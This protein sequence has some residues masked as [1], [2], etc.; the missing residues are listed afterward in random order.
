MSHCNPLIHR[1]S[2]KKHLLLFICFIAVTGL[3]AQDK[4]FSL[5]FA[6]NPN[7]GWISAEDTEIEDNID[8]SSSGA[9]LGFS[10]GVMGEIHFTPNYNLALGIN[11]VFTGGKFSGT[12]NNST[13]DPTSSTPKVYSAVSYEPAKLSY[14][15]IPA[16]LR[17][18][19]NEIGYISYFGNIGFAFDFALNGKADAVLS[20]L[21]LDDN[22]EVVAF[23]QRQLDSDIRFNTSFLNPYFVVGLGG[24]YSLGGNS[25]VHVGI[26]Y[27]SGLG[28][29]VS[30]TETEKYSNIFSDSKFT[31]SY[32]SLNIGIFL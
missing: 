7:L 8:V 3:N 14:I 6:A 2:M 10:Y 24:Q 20:G 19:T 13:P 1:K 4:K 17:L 12:N 18:K 15:H 28:N 31:N 16:L 27:N 21:E 11:H 5:G 32:V 9:R 23:N 26:D 25:R 29:I 30:K 22:N